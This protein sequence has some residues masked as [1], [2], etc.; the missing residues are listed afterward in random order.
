[1]ANE[2]RKLAWST[3]W[4]EASALIWAVGVR[5]FN[6]EGHGKGADKRRDGTDFN[7]QDM[8]INQLWPGFV[9]GEWHNNHHLYSNSARA[10]FLRHQ[11]DLAWWYIYGLYMIGAVSSYNDSRQAFYEKHYRN[12]DRSL[13]GKTGMESGRR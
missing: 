13:L 5:T 12:P 10:G 2:R 11:L 3:V 4:H 6:Y 1:M 8:S 7:R 9:A